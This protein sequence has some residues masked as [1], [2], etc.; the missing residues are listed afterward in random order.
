MLLDA[1]ADILLSPKNVLPFGNKAGLPTYGD[2]APN[3]VMAVA[4]DSHRSSRCWPLDKRR[5]L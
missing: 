2:C 1:V 5:C 3:T 4:T